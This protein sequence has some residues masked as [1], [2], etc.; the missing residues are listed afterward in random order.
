[1][2][3]NSNLKLILEEALSLLPAKVQAHYVAIF[4][5]LAE[6]HYVFFLRTMPTSSE[7]LF[8]IDRLRVERKKAHKKTRKSSIL[9][10][11]FVYND[12]EITTRLD[13]AQEAW[14]SLRLL[15]YKLPKDLVASTHFKTIEKYLDELRGEV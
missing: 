5:T 10:I 14:E 11:D 7:Y 15:S 1:M 12:L 8:R 3:N 13:S 2:K 4:N 6:H 9:T